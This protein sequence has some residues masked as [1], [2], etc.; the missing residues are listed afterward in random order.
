[1][2]KTFSKWLESIDAKN[3]GMRDAVFTMIKDAFKD[4][5]KVDVD[6]SE[7]MNM[8]TNNLPKMAKRKIINWGPINDNPDLVKEIQTGDM[9]I[10]DLID[11]LS[12][13]SND[14]QPLPQKS[15]MPVNNVL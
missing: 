9:Q 13:V 5:M 4:E 3:I 15:G 8:S 11:R 12:G 7:I 14:I 2:I 6:D 1:M 10:S